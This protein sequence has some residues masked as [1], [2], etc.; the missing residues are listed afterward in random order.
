MTCQNAML[1]LVDDDESVRRSMARLLKSAGHQVQTFAS[2]QEFLEKGEFTQ[3][4]ACVIL[5]V[6]MPGLSGLDLQNELQKTH[7][8]LAIVFITGYGDI[9]TSVRA[10]KGGAVDFLTKPVD[11]GDLLRA[12]ESALARAVVDHARRAELNAI[13]LLIET[14]T[15]RE[16]DVMALV[17]TGR[18]NK[19]IAGELGTVEKTV[20]VHRA[21]VMEK[22][23]VKSLAELVST[24][25][26]LS[27]SERKTT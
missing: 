9:P 22:M 26:K 15:P 20:K 8:P 19:Q 11:D 17:V 13:K 6:Q 16:R 25:Q 14:L 21:R 18:L 2:A 27:E 5:D 1:F 10:I 12:V 24:V 3:K 23:K 7:A 4:P